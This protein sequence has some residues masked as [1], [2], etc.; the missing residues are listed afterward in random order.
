LT[1]CAI[2]ANIVAFEQGSHNHFRN[3]AELFILQVEHPAKVNFSCKMCTT[4]QGSSIFKVYKKIDHQKTQIKL[5]VQCI[6]DKYASFL[7]P[8]PLYINAA[9]IK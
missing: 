5:A 2:A 1:Q 9:Y 6:L 3:Y 4:V 8:F 7:E